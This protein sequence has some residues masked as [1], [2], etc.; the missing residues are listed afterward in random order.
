[1]FFLFCLGV[2]ARRVLFCH[3]ERVFVS[4]GPG[5]REALKRKKTTTKKTAGASTA[6]SSVLTLIKLQSI[7]AKCQEMLGCSVI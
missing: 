6:D 7:S 2:C 5:N 4:S 3:I 1:M